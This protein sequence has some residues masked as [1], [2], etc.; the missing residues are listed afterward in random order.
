MPDGILVLFPEA[1]DELS[2]AQVPYLEPVLLPGRGYESVVQYAHLRNRRSVREY[3]EALPILD[4][5][6]ADRSIG[7][8]RSGKVSLEV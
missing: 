4:G 2:R 1:S 8:A 5:P 3:L 6:E 7:G